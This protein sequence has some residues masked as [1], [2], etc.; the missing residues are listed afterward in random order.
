MNILGINAFHGDAAVALLKDG[1]LASA[2]EE[3][4]LNRRNRHQRRD[5]Q[6]RFG[7]HSIQLM[8]NDAASGGT[9][10]SPVI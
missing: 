4:R 9:S 1:Q 5:N 7:S 6:E 2:M 10:R 8:S 3:E